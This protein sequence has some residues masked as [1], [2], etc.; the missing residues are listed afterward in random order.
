MHYIHPPGDFCDYKKIGGHCMSETMLIDL[1]PVSVDIDAIDEQIEQE[2]KTNLTVAIQTDVLKKAVS[3]VER[4]VSKKAVQDIQKTIYLEFQENKIILR[5]VNSNYMTEVTVAQ[6]QEQTNFKMTAGKPGAVCFS[7][8]KLIPMIKTLKHKDTEIKIDGF[9]GVIKSGRTKHDLQG[10]DSY[11]FPEVP[12]VEDGVTLAVESSLLSM[13]YDRTMYA[14]STKETRPVITGVHHKLAGSELKCVA[15]DSHRLSQFVC[16][17]KGTHPEVNATIPVT[18]MAEAKK[19]LDSI[20]GNIAV[21]FC[22]GRVVYSFEG[23]RVFVSLLEGSYPDTDRLIAPP[24]ASATRF[25]LNVGEFRDLLAGSTV[26]NPNQPIIIRIK[27]QDNMIRINTREAGVSAFQADIASKNGEGNDLAVGVNVRY[28]QDVL[29]RY[30]N[31]DNIALS[32]LPVNSNGAAPGLQ[33]FQC[34]LVNGDERCLEL[35]VPV[36]SQEIDYNGPVVIE[37]FE[38][39]IASSFNPFE[40]DFG[41]IS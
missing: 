6:N 29:A 7:G 20:D 40:Q 33:P 22:E 1:D 25:E 35:F 26:C 17:V 18:A 10:M 38:G 8:E 16:E 3:Q 41:G 31:E 11:L 39:T 14:A 30:S 28:L 2:M 24:E 21:Q 4:A 23:V 32:F 9:N 5:G 15:T 36:R 13:I 27:A 37:N 12:E 34:N 19:H